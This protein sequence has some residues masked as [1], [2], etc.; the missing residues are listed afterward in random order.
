MDQ[1][2]GVG[3]DRPHA[4]RRASR[5]WCRSGRRRSRR[6]S[7]RRAARPP[8]ASSID[9]PLVDRDAG[10]ADDVRQERLARRP[11]ARREHS[12]ASA[13]ASADADA[14]SLRPP[15]P[16]ELILQLQVGLGDRQVLSA[17]DVGLVADEHAD[18]AV[19]E[20]RRAR[21]CGT[22]PAATPRCSGAI[23]RVGSPAISAS[24]VSRHMRSNVYDAV[25]GLLDRRADHDRA[26]ADEDD[27]VGVADRVG[28][29]RAGVGVEHLALVLVDERAARRRTCTRPGA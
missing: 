24:A 6:G 22:R 17:E 1:Q 20:R 12:H 25:R 7:T 27:A 21:G 14:V 13:Y 28:E 4:L 26:V 16:V 23:S 18:R 11:Q 9:A 2:F 8:M 19:P 3:S 29:P 10:G 15:A 5:R